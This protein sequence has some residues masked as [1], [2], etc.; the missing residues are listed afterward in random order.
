MAINISAKNDYSMLFSS[1]Q[2]NS[3]NVTSSIFGN[4]SSSSFSL[5]DYALIKSGSYGKLMKAYYA[6]GDSKNNT[7]LNKLAT[8]SATDSASTIT[9]LKSSSDS[10]SKAA[11]A[12]T[13]TGKKSVFEK[14][15][16]TTKD[17]FG[18]ETTTQE[19]DKDAI[20]D[21]V[22]EFAKAYNSVVS[23]S[24]KSDN[25]KVLSTAAN[26]VTQTLTYEDL[27]NKVGITIGEDNKLSVDE[28]KFKESDMSTVKTLMNG[29]TSFAYDVQSKASFINMYA[30][31]DATK[32]S[33]LYAQNAL[34]TNSYSSSGY[35]FDSMF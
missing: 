18:V 26:M 23:S 32:T 6:Q 1:L 34:Y 22:A 25:T 33:G 27:L 24:Q 7:A 4:A 15:D 31:A 30:Q 11:S 3:N 21:K 35:M 16:V 19:Y 17:E 13:E 29:V 5:S 10:L 2:T 20:Y 9:A 14:K 8:G 12:L 28:N